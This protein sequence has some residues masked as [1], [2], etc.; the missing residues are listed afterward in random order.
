MYFKIVLGTLVLHCQTSLPASLNRVVS[1]NF[2]GFQRIV[3]CWWLLDVFAMVFNGVQ[4]HVHVF[5]LF[6]QMFSMFCNGFAA[7]T[8]EPPGIIKPCVFNDFPCTSMEYVSFLWF[9]YVLQCFRLLFIIF[10]CFC[11]CFST[12]PGPC[13]TLRSGRYFVHVW[14]DVWA[15]PRSDVVRV[16][17]GVYF[18]YTLGY[19]FF[20]MDDDGWQL[21]VGQLAFGVH[22]W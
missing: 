10:V 21:V 7:L 12:D 11:K 17:F 6:L 9:V 2:N 8:N 22:F 5:S 18:W 3:S 4:Q 13:C 16:C 14:G 20:T 15:D 19:I 1:M